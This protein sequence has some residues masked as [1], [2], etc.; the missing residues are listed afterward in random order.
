MRVMRVLCL[1]AL[2][3]LAVTGCGDDGSSDD[4][5]SGSGGSGGGDGDGDGDGDFDAAVAPPPE[6]GPTWDYV[7]YS[8]IANGGCQSAFCH[9]AFQGMLRMIDQEDAY[10]NL[11]DV[12]AAGPLC[13]M[14]GLK[15]IDPGNPDDS[16]LVLKLRPDPP[17]GDVMPLPPD[18]PISD[19]DLGYLRDWIAAGAPEN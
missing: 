8:V 9:G 15:R 6:K 17:C 18:V 16:L 5:S 11:F 10:A 14:S 4:G 1:A 3:G 12:E 13:D 2:L 19:E 7:Y